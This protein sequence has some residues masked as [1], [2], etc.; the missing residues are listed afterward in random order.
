[1]RK[2][3]FIDCDLR[4]VDFDKAVLREC[5]FT[6]CD[7]TLVTFHQ[8]VALST[9]V[10]DACC[11]GM[12]TIIGARAYKDPRR[13]S[14]GWLVTPMYHFY[15]D[16]TGDDEE[17]DTDDSEKKTVPTRLPTPGHYRS[18]PSVEPEEGD[19]D[20]GNWNLWDED[21]WEDYAYGGYGAYQMPTKAMKRRY[22]YMENAVLECPNIE[23]FR[24]TKN[25]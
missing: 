1:L 24:R 13:K 16:P 8:A 22:G 2:I 12:Q 18:P 23:E 5:R 25:G 6:R 21:D 3:H 14:I 17:E 7:L 20:D 15:D 19:D 4:G 9:C 10:F 11:T